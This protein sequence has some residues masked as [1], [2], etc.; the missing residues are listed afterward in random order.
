[1]P[2]F[3]FIIYATLRE[4][5]SSEKIDRKSRVTEMN[6]NCLCHFASHFSSLWTSK[7]KT[8]LRNRL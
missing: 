4:I 3:T 1:L 6:S 5:A 2:H 7:K 8:R